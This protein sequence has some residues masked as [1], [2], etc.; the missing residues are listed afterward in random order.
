MLNVQDIEVYY[1]VVPVLKEVSLE[2]KEG[3]FV[4]LLGPN[5]AGKTTTVKTL[6]GLL[7]PKSGRIFFDGQDITGQ[8]PHRIVGM[9]ISLVPEGRLLFREMSVLENLDLGASTPKARAK[10]SDS[11]QL[12][13]SLFPHLQMR[14][15]QMAGTLS[16]GQ[17]QMVE[18]GRALMSRPRI[19]FLDE[20]SLGLAPLLIK[21]LFQKLKE[22]NETGISVFLV[23]QNAVQALKISQRAYVLESGKIVFKGASSEFAHSEIISYYV[24]V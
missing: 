8:P 5:G 11:F 6:M 1:G 7:K 14:K 2:V 21:D 20:P 23:E 24:G 12:V 3:E 16:G 22:L 19:L 13:F 15:S 10:F 9:G 18:I 4:S 17:Q